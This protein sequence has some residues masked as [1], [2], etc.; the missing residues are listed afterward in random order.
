MA[1]VTKKGA[2]LAVMTL[3]KGDLFTF[4]MILERMGASN[5]FDEKSLEAL[6]LF[7]VEELD[8][9]L[10]QAGFKGFTY[11]IYGVSIVFHAEKG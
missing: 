8:N 6:H 3:V 4:K 10:A 1:R 5:L 11:T 9:Y 2:R 7:D